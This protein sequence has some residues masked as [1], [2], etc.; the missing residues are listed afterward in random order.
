[1]VRMEEALREE[2]GCGDVRSLGAGGSGCISSADVYL[3]DGRKVFV[4]K[5]S[6]PEARIMFDGE[7]AGLSAIHETQT[8]KVPKPLKVFDH[9][10]CCY[11]AMEHYDMR[12][13][14]QQA[15]NFGAKLAKLHL[16]NKVK[17]VKSLKSSGF[18][19][20]REEGVRS[21]GFEVYTCCGIIAMPN[22]WSSNWLEFYARNRLKAQLDLVEKNYQDREALE[23]W[24]Q[25]ERNLHKLIPVGLEI[26]P[27][28]LHGD[29]WSGNTAEVDG[30]PCVYDP[31]C[32]YG[33][34]EFDLSIAR[35]FGG[36]PR[37]V[38][39]AYHGVIPQDKGFEDRQKLYQ[40]FHYLN[41][42]NHFGGGYRG[43]S[44]A[45]MKQLAKL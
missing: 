5:N 17:I 16:S 33:H 31:A 13:L 32:L 41:H 28:L 36:L 18:V 44:I 11:L 4:K 21:F 23:L 45:I 15:E 2:L 6:K 38:F 7:S 29:L 37:K 8:I 10:G 22:D 39:A 9:N 19:G 1:Y 40:L 3:C 25:V 27:A 34:H 20:K 26:T 43:Q 42:W 12:S 30:E 24:P 35:M 14:H